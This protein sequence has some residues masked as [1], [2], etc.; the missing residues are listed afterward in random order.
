MRTPNNRKVKVSKDNQEKYLNLGY[1][2]ID[3]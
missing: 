3:N 1:T 2:L